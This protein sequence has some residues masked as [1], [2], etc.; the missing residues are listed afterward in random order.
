MLSQQVLSGWWCS[1]KTTIADSLVSSTVLA[2]ARPPANL[3]ILSMS[4]HRGISTLPD[5]DQRPHL[6]ATHLPIGERG[7][8]AHTPASDQRI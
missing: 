7:R 4:G 2:R 5:S 6:D 3:R 1:S 8:P